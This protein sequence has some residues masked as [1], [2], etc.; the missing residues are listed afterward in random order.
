[1]QAISGP[2]R[3]QAIGYTGG[4]LVFI[5]GC[6]RSGT[7]WLQRLLAGHPKVRTGQEPCV[8]RSYVAPQLRAWRWELTRERD[9]KTATGRGGVGLSCYF[10]EHEFL[11]VLK[12][13]MYQLLRPMIGN[14]QPG[15]L[16][17]DKTPVNAMCL[18]EIS[19]LLPDSRFIYL[20]RDPRDVVASLLAA[21][22]TWG[23]GWA[24]RTARE[25]VKIW[26]KFVRAA[27]IA[28]KDIPSHRFLEIRYEKLL[29]SP[30]D[31]LLKVAQFLNLQ[32]DREAVKGVVTNNKAKLVKE[33]G[34]TPIPVYGEV[35][36][37]VGHVVRDPAAFIQSAGHGGWKKQLRFREKFVVWRKARNLMR[38][39]GYACSWRDWIGGGFLW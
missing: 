8:F 37:R 36:Q 30:E 15:E 17:V 18:A 24:P 5:V 6:S 21:Y 31:T 29:A 12:N 4:N 23:A 13:Y 20:L 26:I 14:L 2:E 3:D 19:E 34:G 1:M 39:K 16:F 28:A 33:G 25:A 27:D 11:A 10:Q 35:A 9:P 38:Q 7:T 22:R 32:W